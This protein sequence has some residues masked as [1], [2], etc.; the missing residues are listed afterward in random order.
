[1]DYAPT[2]QTPSQVSLV[3]DDNNYAA[4]KLYSLLLS[5]R[6]I[7]SEENMALPYE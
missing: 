1:M 7:R 6:N 5:I 4:F 3:H 2:F